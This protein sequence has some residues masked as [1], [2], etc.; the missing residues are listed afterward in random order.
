M[1]LSRAAPGE[2]YVSRYLLGS[3][4]SLAHG[5]PHLWGLPTAA[6]HAKPLPARVHGPTHPA[7]AARTRPPARH[8]WLGL[9]PQPRARDEGLL[10]MCS[11]QPGTQGRGPGAGPPGANAS[12]AP[13]PATAGDLIYPSLT[14][15]YNPRHLRGHG[16]PVGLSAARPALDRVSCADPGSPVGWR[17]HRAE[18]AAGPW[19]IQLARG[20]GA[21][22]GTP[23]R[24][25]Q[26]LRQATALGSSPTI[27]G[28]PRMQFP[29]GWCGLPSRSTGRWGPEDTPQGEKGPRQRRPSAGQRAKGLVLQG[30]DRCRQT[31][32]G[33][34][35]SEDLGEWADGTMLSP[36]SCPGLLGGGQTQV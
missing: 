36:D 13:G 10:R 35:C 31:G 2:T 28:P 33:P 15:R 26:P 21:E 27:T 34:P 30:A 8:A 16:K 5:P 29:R 20:A 1:H 9:G 11:E 14:G 24:S 7:A 12:W 25:Q 17:L 19:Q 18:A 3:L 6:A 22:G 23:G 32:S 4:K